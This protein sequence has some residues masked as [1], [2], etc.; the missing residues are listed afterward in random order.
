[1]VRGCRSCPG[2]PEGSSAA[3]VVRD[4]LEECFAADLLKPAQDEATEPVVLELSIDR[5]NVPAAVI[6]PAAFGACHTR[7]P[8]LQRHR[9]AAATPRALADGLGGGSLFVGR[10]WGV[11]GDVAGRMLGQGDDVGLGGG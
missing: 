7:S 1:M 9:L 5:L 4:G 6:D 3:Q 11:D 8:L 2:E 10:R